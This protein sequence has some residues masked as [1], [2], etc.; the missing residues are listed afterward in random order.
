MSG[1]NNSKTAPSSSSS[2]NTNTN[3]T[4][5]D[6]KT[7]TP[8]STEKGK[9]NTTSSSSTGTA[10]NGTN[11]DSGG[12]RGHRQKGAGTVV[13]SKGEV[14]VA[15]ITMKDW[16]KTPQTLLLEH[17]QHVKRPKPRYD[18]LRDEGDGIR[19]R[20]VLQDPKRPGTDKDLI[21]LPTRGFQDDN[22]AKHTVALLALH[23][24]LPTLQLELKLPEPY[25]TLWLTLTGRISA[26]APNEKETEPNDNSSTTTTNQ[27]NNKSTK[28]SINTATE[29]TVSPVITKVVPPT[30][31]STTNSSTSTTPSSSTAASTTPVNATSDTNIRTKKQ[32]V[33]PLDVRLANKHT[34]V[35]DQKRERIESERR[36]AER[37]NRKET[38]LRE[39]LSK[40]NESYIQ[41]SS[42]TRNYVESVLKIINEEI[43]MGTSNNTTNNNHQDT[44]NSN[45]IDNITSTII[46]HRIE[47]ETDEELLDLLDIIQ[48]ILEYLHKEIHHGQSLTMTNITIDTAFDQDIIH[49]LLQTIP[50]LYTSVLTELEI[51]GFTNQN[52]YLEHALNQ[53]FTNACIEANMAAKTIGKSLILFIFPS[54]NNIGSS[55]P[56]NA[57]ATTTTWLVPDLLLSYAIDWLCLYVPEDQLPKAFDPRGKTI[58]FH[59]VADLLNN[60]NTNNST[61]NAST[62]TLH[63]SHQHSVSGNTT[64]SSTVE[65]PEIVTLFPTSKSSSSSSSAISQHSIA[66]NTL[67]SYGLS[68]SDS[69]IIIDN[70]E[71]LIISQ[72]NHPFLGN[73]FMQL[74]QCSNQFTYLCTTYLQTYIYQQS[75]FLINDGNALYTNLLSNS[76]DNLVLGLP[77]S[78]CTQ[79]PTTNVV[80]DDPLFMAA[81]EIEAA[82]GIYGDDFHVQ[83]LA[84][85][86]SLVSWYLNIPEDEL[87]G[88]N[89]NIQYVWKKLS[90]KLHSSSSGSDTLM[91]NVLDGSI[92]HMMYIGIEPKTNLPTEVATSTTDSSVVYDL[93]WKPTVEI[94]YS[95][96]SDIA[97]SLS[98]NVMAKL[99]PNSLPQLWISYAHYTGGISTT[100]ILPNEQLYR[101]SACLNLSLHLQ[102]ILM[103]VYK[104]NSTYV[105]NTGTF[106]TLLYEIGSLCS[107]LAGEPERILHPPS[108]FQKASVSSSTTKTSTGKGNNTTKSSTTSKKSK[109]NYHQNNKGMDNNGHR[110]FHISSSMD[111]ALN[112]EDKYWMQQYTTKQNESAYQNMNSIRNKLP[113]ASYRDKVVHLVN[114]HQIILL[115][116]ETGCGK[117]TQVPQFLLEDAISKGKGGHVRILCTQ[118]RRI[119]AIGVAQRVANERCEPLG[120]S[121]GAIGY[122]IR[123]E[124]KAHSGTLLLFTT[125]GVLLRRL[126]NGLGHV[127]HIIV[128]EVHER[129][130]DTDFLLAVLRKILPHRPDIKLILMSATMDAV[131]F[132]SYFN[133]I[134][135]NNGI[136][137]TNDKVSGMTVENN[138]KSNT[139]KIANWEEAANS[140]SLSDNNNQVPIISVPGFVHPVKEVYLEDVLG[141]TGYIP[142]LRDK[143]GKLI[144]KIHMNSP[145]TT[146]ENNDDNDDNVNDVYDLIDENDII[147]EGKNGNNRI[148]VDKVLPLTPAS[149]DLR[150]WKS[151]GL[152]YG[153]VASLIYYL[154]H[155]TNSPHKHDDGSILVFMPGSIEIRKLHREIEKLGSVHHLLILHLHGS[156]TAA[157]QALV[158]QRA[159]PGKRKVVLATNVA[160]TSITIDDITIVIDTFRVK[161]SQYDAVNRM[162]KLVETWTSQAASKQRRG[163]AGRVRPGTC[164]RL[165]PKD[166]LGTLPMQTTPEIQ[167]TPL[168]SLCLHVKLLKLGKIKEFMNSLL[169]PPTATALKSALNNLIE[170]GALQKI[171]I[172]TNTGITQTMDVELTSLGYHLALLPMDVRLGKALI[173]SS[174][175]R[176]VDSI[177]TITA[178]LSE[179]S[180][181]RPIVPSMDEDVKLRMQKARDKFDWGQSDHLAIVRAFNLWRDSGNWNQRRQFADDHYLSHETLRSMADLRTEYAGVLSDLGF[182]PGKLNTERKNIKSNTT[183]VTP[184]IEDNDGVGEMDEYSDDES[185]ILGTNNSIISSNASSVT[186][187][188]VSTNKSSGKQQTS[189]IPIHTY[190]RFGELDPSVNACSDQINILRA[191][192]VAGFYPHVVKVVTPPRKYHDTISGAVRMDFK[193]QELRMYTLHEDTEESNNLSSTNNTN[194]NKGKKEVLSKS[195]KGNVKNNPKDNDTE[196][197]SDSSSETDS[198]AEI[199]AKREKTLSNGQCVA[200]WRG[201]LQDRVF[202]HPSSYCFSIGEYRCPWLIYHEKI[203]TSKI[204][205]RD[206]SVITPYSMILFGGPLDVNFREGKI[207]VG[208]K[209]W[210]SFLAEPRIGVLIKGLRNNLLRLLAHKIAYPEF[211]IASSPIIEVMLHILINNGM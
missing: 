197:L 128:D 180:P 21:F 24:L 198:D 20:V 135:Q 194:N 149:M 45:D 51:L 175:L 146:T 150:G 91:N 201:F 177:L 111:Q 97:S 167:R 88:T 1:K 95:I 53:A 152:D 102:S 47:Q 78:T 103:D 144:N 193:A 69:I 114:N 138:V 208:T 38:K 113:I 156:L 159:P 161:E 120:T 82:A 154:G 155:P 118:P 147:V 185:T 205:I 139:N 11:K 151:H 32:H 189:S 166:M 40:H 41:M 28:S 130:V 153:L 117:T 123:G 54:L 121:G 209:K 137:I 126:V 74:L 23:N 142:M 105:S 184:I 65:Q 33:I 124:K 4:S 174:L 132:A 140:L 55:T 46:S 206:T 57:T 176:C 68:K 98:P 70:M 100:T 86:L 60:S 163:R 181:F 26:S 186:S 77:W 83:Y 81:Q 72:T 8:V 182:L 168:E 62:S 165:I 200:E 190:G 127:T 75:K 80:C 108:I 49:Q 109:R 143:K 56:T 157:E 136:K 92:L 145:S 5:K 29:A 106:M 191:V 107:T 71:Q 42:M 93:E 14:T 170:M 16:M 119:A 76:S 67:L 12:G 52:K 44:S 34:S 141:M 9:S 79:I 104:G 158:F 43:K 188:A 10:P 73:L 179:K 2:S 50:K 85:P 116:G 7:T 3:Q 36:K 178:A 131:S 210:I 6:K 61:T 164:Y 18:I 171:Q 59:K 48:Y 183:T 22:E 110:P 122:Q 199:L 87:L 195:S 66:L 203:S 162:A 96:L 129:G 204:F 160:E 90:I 39:L 94:D 112:K 192:L 17:T 115:S 15:G 196:S 25:R 13:V 19:Y 133:T 125:T 187:S 202:I 169:D 37:K 173:Y 31:P 30:L 58:E 99:Y 101:T 211:D 172:Q 134:V 148:M 27:S 207:T 64:T 84:I 35:A 63:K 89:T